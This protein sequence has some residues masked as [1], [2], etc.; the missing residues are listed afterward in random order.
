MGY[1]SPTFTKKF[2]YPSMIF[3]KTQPTINN[4]K[5]GTIW[6][7]GSWYEYLLWSPEAVLMVRW[8]TGT[9]EFDQPLNREQNGQQGRFKA[10]HK[11]KL[12]GL[13]ECSDK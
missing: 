12:V 6:G 11:I 13:W 5:G 1:L 9:F 3:K 7:R 10:I 8:M 2:W 4:E